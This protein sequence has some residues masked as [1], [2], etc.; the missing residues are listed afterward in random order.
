MLLDV[1]IADEKPSRDLDDEL[2][3]FSSSNKRIVTLSRF[4]IEFVGIFT[5]NTKLGSQLVKLLCENLDIDTEKAYLK[6]ILLEWIKYVN[7]RKEAGQ[8]HIYIYI[9]LWEMQGGTSTKN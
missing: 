2:L 6:S 9:S 8:K 5:D 3:D 4:K 1:D 7:Q